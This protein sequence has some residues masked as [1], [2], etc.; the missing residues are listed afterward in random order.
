MQCNASQHW[1]GLL[2]VETNEDKSLD[3]IDTMHTKWLV[4]IGPYLAGPLALQMQQRPTHRCDTGEKLTTK[5]QWSV[6]FVYA[7]VC[8]SRF[9]EVS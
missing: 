5:A 4:A 9:I 2:V 3:T 1:S 6:L 8:G 7:C